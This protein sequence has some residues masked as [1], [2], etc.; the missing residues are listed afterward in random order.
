M[1]WVIGIVLAALFWFLSTLGFVDQI[2]EV[3]LVQ[4]LGLNFHTVL[5]QMG[6]I[7]IMFPIVDMI[8]LKPLKQALDE[9]T[10][11]IE[12]TYSEADSLKARMEELKS[13]YEKRLQDAESEAR[14]KIQSAIHEAEQLKQNMIAE[15]RTQAEEIRAKGEADL[16]RERAKMLVDLRAQAVNLTLTAT[17][18]LIGA[19]MDE[20][21]QRKLAQQFIETAEVGS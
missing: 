6:V 12:D 5:V 16:N 4:Q 15:A 1:N 18:K 19:S 7:S 2:N 17:E 13:S 21:R 9:R 20:E 11:Y 14:T 3:G 8:F 10:K